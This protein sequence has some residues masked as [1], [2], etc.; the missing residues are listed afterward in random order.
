MT[1]IQS[2]VNTNNHAVLAIPNSAKEIGASSFN[3]IS[4]SSSENLKPRSDHQ[5]LSMAS[6]FSGTSRLKKAG[7]YVGKTLAPVLNG[8]KKAGS[9]VASARPGAQQSEPTTKKGFLKH[10][11]GPKG[12]VVESAFPQRRDPL[13]SK[14]SGPQTVQEKQAPAQEKQAP[15]QNKP[16]SVKDQL[17]ATTKS[18]A[19]APQTIQEA[20]ALIL[21]EA[22]KFKASG[23]GGVASTGVFL[24]KECAISPDSNPKSAMLFT[25]IA[26]KFVSC[27][28]TFVI[29]K[30]AAG[31]PL[32]E[33]FSK[34][35]EKAK[36][37]TSMGAGRGIGRNRGPAAAP[38]LKGG[39]LFAGRIQGEDMSRP[40]AKHRFLDKSNT[41]AQEDLGKIWV[42]D[43]A[44]GNSD[45]FSQTGS[46]TN[47]GN[48]MMDTTTSVIYPID[49][50]CLF[51][52]SYD[53]DDETLS[54]SFNYAVK[55]MNGITPLLDKMLSGFLG[56]SGQDKSNSDIDFESI[57]SNFISG[58]KEVLENISTDDIKGA[59]QDVYGNNI[60]SHHMDEAQGAIDAMKT[61]LGV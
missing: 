57:K 59:Y 3:T 56:V 45:R 41:A 22:F 6:P 4:L 33:I 21:K 46:G 53:G 14:A 26:K 48:I 30:P 12:S 32:S 60:L 28:A 43:V 16:V 1:P 18:K 58:A 24:G 34:F 42:L 51:E 7:N 5:A 2:Q 20:K 55:E 47:A 40:E 35:E 61:Q 9:K 31:D 38:Q 50:E 25:S 23:N 52:P 44:L 54:D 10:F 13:A 39:V 11:R 17:S 19:S 49:N 29:P 8:I 15:V 37:D 36:P 27:P